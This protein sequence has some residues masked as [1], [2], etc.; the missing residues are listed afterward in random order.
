MVEVILMFQVKNNDS[1]DYN[2]SSE[3]E[4]KYIDNVIYFRARP[5]H[6]RSEIGA[7]CRIHEK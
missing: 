7:I 4:E 2:G 5:N 6:V 1:F 3:Y